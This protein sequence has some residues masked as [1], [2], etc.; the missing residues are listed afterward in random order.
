MTHNAKYLHQPP[1]L[2][3]MYGK[4]ILPGR[5]KPPQDVDLPALSAELLG[6]STGGS[7]LARY[8]KVCGLEPRVAVPITWPHILAFP[9][10]LRVLTDSRFPLPLLGLVHLRNRITQYRAIGEWESLDIRV[11]LGDKRATER[12]LEFD[13][14]TEARS[15]GQLAWEESSTY[16]FR[17]PQGS[18]GGKAHK[19]PPSLSTFSNSHTI[20]VPEST[21][22]QY[23]EVSGDRNPIHLYPLT[24]KLFGFPR[25]IAH[26]M[27]SKAR[28]LGYLEQ[29][30][31][32]KS[33]RFSVTC[34]FK[35]PVFLPGEARI[36][37]QA[38]AKGLDFQLLNKNG[39]APHLTGN[40]SWL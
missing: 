12:G 22:R 15:A 25:A 16:L 33:D 8:R 23:A 36:N 10:H 5:G 9:L 3:P 7:E 35:K 27:W 14:I 17:H 34:D 20:G 28:V 26:G 21:G 29:Q 40:V 18:S 2:L 39:D 6:V 32:W 38:S 30:T 31:D 4:A 19:Q 13:L 24:A 37:W 11:T 1:S